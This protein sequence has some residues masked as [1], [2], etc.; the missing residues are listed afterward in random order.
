MCLSYAIYK[1]AS[2][3]SI[4]ELKIQKQKQNEHTR[5]VMLCIYFLTFSVFLSHLFPRITDACYSKGSI[6]GGTHWSQTRADLVG[7]LDH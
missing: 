4:H 7:P 5:F 1:T 3:V 2:K 6:V